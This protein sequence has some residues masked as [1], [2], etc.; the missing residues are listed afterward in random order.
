MQQNGERRPVTPPG[1]GRNIRI[2]MCD[3]GMPTITES[4]THL[5]PKDTSMFRRDSTLIGYSESN[6]EC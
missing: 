6:L 5:R 2:A 4:L 3:H 1:L